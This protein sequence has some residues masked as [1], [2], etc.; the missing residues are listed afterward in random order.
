MTHGRSGHDP[1]P[2]KRAAPSK[3]APAPVRE[4][5]PVGPIR[6]TIRV[7]NPRGLHP[8]II[9]LFT[10]TAKKYTSAVTLGYGE[11][12]ADG[13]SVWDL[14]MLVVLPDSE[15]VLEVDGPDAPIAVEP[16]TEILASPGGEDYTI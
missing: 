7:I 10:K 5:A 12:R 3:A 6:R 9:D 1:G 11:M 15:V 13:K 2:Q 8:R 4:S 14:I 16:L